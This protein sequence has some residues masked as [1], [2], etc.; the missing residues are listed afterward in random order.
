MKRRTFLKSLGAA[1][2]SIPFV[3]EISLAASN[4]V[5]STQ[6]YETVYAHKLRDKAFVIA[7]KEL[8]SM[9]IAGVSRNLMIQKAIEC[10]KNG[11]KLRLIVDS[12]KYRPSPTSTGEFAIRNHVP[13]GVVYSAHQVLLINRDNTVT[14]KKG[15]EK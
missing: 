12:R 4:A 14:V 3:T 11:K 1:A 2:A 15:V 7:K 8:G 13:L 10:A 9:G 5:A 6:G